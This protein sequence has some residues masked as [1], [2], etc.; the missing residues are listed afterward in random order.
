MNF[1]FVFCLLAFDWLSVADCCVC[2]FNQ[3]AKSYW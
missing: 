3:S 2:S 1:V